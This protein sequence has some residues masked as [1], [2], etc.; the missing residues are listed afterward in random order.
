MCW[1]IFHWHTRQLL[2][3]E[4]S[5]RWI[6]VD[7]ASNQWWLC[8]D[9]VRW[10]MVQNPSN[11]TNGKYSWHLHWFP[12]WEQRLHRSTITPSRLGGNRRFSIELTNDQDTL[13]YN[14]FL[15][16]SWICLMTVKCQTNSAN[17]I[18]LMKEI[19]LTHRDM[20]SIYWLWHLINCTTHWNPFTW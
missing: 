3:I 19:W 15:F 20:W 16:V 7:R 13:L 14:C 10:Y 2:G 11:G 17:I 1:W 18:S 8:D 5:R 9:V 6:I 12:C 4:L